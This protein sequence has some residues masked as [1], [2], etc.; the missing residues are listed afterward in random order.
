MANTI[1]DINLHQLF[2]DHTQLDRVL[3]SICLDEGVSY[4]TALEQLQAGTES[5]YNSGESTLG[6]ALAYTPADGE[7]VAESLTLLE[8]RDGAVQAAYEQAAPL[9]PL[10]HLDDQG[11]VLLLDQQRDGAADLRGVQR[12]FGFVDG[13]RVEI[14]AGD[15]ARLDG[16]RYEQVMNQPVHSARYF[17]ASKLDAR[18]DNNPEAWRTDDQ[19]MAGA[20]VDLLRTLQRP[21]EL[22]AARAHA[23]RAAGRVAAQLDQAIAG[24]ADKRQKLRRLD[25][26]IA[27]LEGAAPGVSFDSAR[28]QVQSQAAKAGK[29][30]PLRMLDQIEADIARDREELKRLAQD[31]TPGQFIRTLDAYRRGEPLPSATPQ[32]S[33]AQDDAEAL[34]RAGVHPG[35][36]AIHERV[37]ERLR[38]LDA[39]E[40]DYPKVLAQIMREGM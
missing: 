38:E 17:A 28:G 40:S 7:Y 19:R 12:Q 22:A 31:Q 35:S 2:N 13:Q 23:N 16:A 25:Q 20:G 1:L 24:A 6:A 37:V 3:R 8:R 29:E 4:M 33:A 27:K 10:E 30:E 11:R 26:E 18:Y 36:H 34:M 32:T 21:G 39:P 5:A 14:P 9:I 15:R